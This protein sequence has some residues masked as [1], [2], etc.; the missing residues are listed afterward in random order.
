ML[1]CSLPLSSDHG[2][3]RGGHRMVRGGGGLAH[4]APHGALNQN[5]RHPEGKG[6]GGGSSHLRVVCTKV[7]E[8][9]WA[10][11]GLHHLLERQ[12]RPPICGVT[13]QPTGHRLLHLYVSAPLKRTGMTH[14]TKSKPSNRKKALHTTLYPARS[15]EISRFLS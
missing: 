3:G 13:Q 9:R 1:I 4:S 6:G 15:N 12:V 11:E 5:V 2:R 8:P 7:E 10:H 14:N